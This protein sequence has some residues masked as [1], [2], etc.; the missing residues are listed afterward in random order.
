MTELGDGP[1]QKMW[2]SPQQHIRTVVPAVHQDALIFG[3]GGT[4]KRL[5]GIASLPPLHKGGRWGVQQAREAG[6]CRLGLHFHA[7]VMDG[8]L[9]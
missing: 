8:R 2:H 4:G 7:A 5:C 6:Q 9:Y 3:M 1:S